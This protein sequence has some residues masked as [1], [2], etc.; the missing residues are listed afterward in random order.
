MIIERYGPVKQKSIVNILLLDT[1]M[2]KKE[3]KKINFIN[4]SLFI[5][6]VR[7]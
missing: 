4:F 7:G 2:I 1:E 5:F 3:R 6:E